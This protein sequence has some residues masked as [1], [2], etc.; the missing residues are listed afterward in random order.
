M[1]A[2][3]VILSVTCDALGFQLFKVQVPLHGTPVAPCTGCLCVLAIQRPAGV[4][5][6]TERDVLPVAGGMAG[7]ALVPVAATVALVAI[8]TGVAGNAQHGQLLQRHARLRHAE[9]GAVTAFATRLPMLAGQRELRRTVVV[10]LGRLPGPLVMTGFALFA[11]AALVA[12]LLV[13]FL[14]AGHAPV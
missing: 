7:L 14:V 10:E 12:L 4:P 3:E 8:I 1:T 6:V 13:V 2:L 11:L 9:S 5:V